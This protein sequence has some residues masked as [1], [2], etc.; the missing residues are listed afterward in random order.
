MYKNIVEFWYEIV[1]LNSTTLFW[2]LKCD[3]EQFNISSKTN[4]SM[5]VFQKTKQRIYC[6]FFIVQKILQMP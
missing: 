4:M 5:I 6:C 1:K 3:V 2:T